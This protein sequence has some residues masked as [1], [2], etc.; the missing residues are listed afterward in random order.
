MIATPEIGVSTPAAFAD[1]DKKWATKST[2]AK[3]TDIKLTER[4]SSDRIN[5][6]SRTIMNG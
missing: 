5:T 6:F 3:V 4:E 1:W 2:A